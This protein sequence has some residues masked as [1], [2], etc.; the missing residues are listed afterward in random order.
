MSDEIKIENIDEFRKN[1]YIKSE[2]EYLK[3]Y[4]DS[5][6]DI[7][8]FWLSKIN[9]LD[10]IKKP[11]KAFDDKGDKHFTWFED[12]KINACYNCLDRHLEKNPNKKALIWIS[13]DGSEKIEFTYKQLY[14]KVCKFSNVLLSKGICKGDRVSIYLPM[15]PE[16]VISVLACARIGAIHSVIFAGYSV[17]TIKQRIEFAESKL[18]ITSDGS[19]RSGKTLNFKKDIDVALESIE[20]KTIENIIIVNR[21]NSEIQ[22]K[23]NEFYWHKEMEMQYFK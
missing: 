3:I 4:T 7:N 17:S 8:K 23:E 5:L 20:N 6:K 2:D 13:Q 16:L 18:L 15:L 9:Y 21:T 14:E 12:G 11:T 19:Y 22:L 1:S 10:W